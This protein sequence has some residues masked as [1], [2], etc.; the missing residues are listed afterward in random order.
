MHVME[1]V[2]FQY[3]TLISYYL[4]TETTFQIYHLWHKGSTSSA[5]A[6]LDQHWAV[7]K[8]ICGQCSSNMVR[9]DCIAEA[10][11]KEGSSEVAQSCP[12]LWDSVDCS[13][14]GSSVHGILQARILEWVAISFSRGSSPPRDQTQV[15]RVVGRCFTLWAT[16]KA[17]PSEK[18]LA[19]K[20][21]SLWTSVWLFTS[22]SYSCLLI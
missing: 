20:P 16:R 14:P 2:N 4:E 15:S 18:G 8:Y 21:E 13:L 5:W 6:S 1:G 3:W 9:E 7:Q 12:T 19:V 17:H 22:N 10:N 11:G